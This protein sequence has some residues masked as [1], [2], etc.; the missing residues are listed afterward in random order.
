VSYPLATVVQVS[1]KDSDVHDDR[2]DRM[3]RHAII[4]G[5]RFGV[6]SALD[7]ND[8]RVMRANRSELMCPY[9]GCATKLV[10]N[11]NKLGTR[12]MRVAANGPTTCVPE[13]AFGGGG[14]ES[15]EHLWLKRRVDY[16]LRKKCNL[17]TKIEDYQTRSDILVTNPRWSIE[18]QRVKTDLEKRTKARED[19]GCQVLWI[20][21]PSAP[22]SIVKRHIFSAPSVRARV[23]QAGNR[24]ATPWKEDYLDVGR[25][26]VTSYVDFCDTVLVRHRGNGR[27]GRGTLG[28]D[29]FLQQVMRGERKWYQHV[30][31]LGTAGWVLDSDLAEAQRLPEVMASPKAPVDKVVIP[32]TAAP[33]GKKNFW[34]RMRHAIRWPW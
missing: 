30:A 3:K 17:R 19:S 2:R 14:P 7:D 11:Q 22:D 29:K 28:A 24:R 15:D 32:T 9:D 4:R 26:S 12:W 23:T 34:Q 33:S 1:S 18:I 8:W 5:D 10:A 13:H 27:L 21:A 25:G 16:L 20:F 6:L 31:V